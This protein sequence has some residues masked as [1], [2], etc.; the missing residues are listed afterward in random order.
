MARA[1]HAEILEGL[2]PGK[3]AATAKRRAHFRTSIVRTKLPPRTRRRR[4][5]SPSICMVG[6][7]ASRPAMFDNAQT[8]SPFSKDSEA[9]LPVGRACRGYPATKERTM[10]AEAYTK[11]V[12]GIWGFIL[13]AIV[14]MLIGFQVA[15]WTTAATTQQMND[16]AVLTS[17]AAIC[18]AQ[19]MRA[20]DHNAKVK[21]LRAMESHLRSE[22]IEKG[23]WDRMPGQ[24][25]ASWGVAA[26]CVTRLDGPEKPGV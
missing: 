22:F 1:L 16:E 4:S 10:S 6:P 17:R 13:G 26:A 23:G 12:N 2:E 20:P 15:G 3:A 14:A 11:L 7:G 19:F 24:E 5:N 21:E 9:Y 8:A 18:A 25:T